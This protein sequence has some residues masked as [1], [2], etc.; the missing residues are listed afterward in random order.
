MFLSPLVQ[1]LNS[2]YSEGL[3]LIVSGHEMLIKAKLILVTMDLQARAS[4]LHMTQHNGKFPCNF[5]MIPGEVVAS[6]KGHTRAFIYEENGRQE[7]LNES[8]RQD[9]K[10]AQ[11]QKKKISGFTGE[12]VLIY[13]TSV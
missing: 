5:C 8:I 1:D 2:L 7:R 4:V 3:K 6:G 12:S 13:M 9:A 10:L 11:Q